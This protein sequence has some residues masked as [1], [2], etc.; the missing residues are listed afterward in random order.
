M[1]SRKGCKINVLCGMCKKKKKKK[2]SRRSGGNVFGNHTR[3]AQIEGH[4]YYRRV[5][6]RWSELGVE[7]NRCIFSEPADRFMRGK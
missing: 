6:A 7:Y 3:R 1:L 4:V 5:A 2:Y